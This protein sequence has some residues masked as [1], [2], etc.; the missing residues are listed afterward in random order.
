M[1]DFLKVKDF[2]VNQTAYLVNMHAG[3]NQDPEIK[4]CK[5]LSVGRKYVKVDSILC[6]EFKI[7]EN[8]RV[9]SGLVEKEYSGEDRQLFLTE[10]DAVDYI[11]RDVLL[12]RLLHEFLTSS[13]F[14]LL[15]LEKICQILGI[16]DV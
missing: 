2:K 4:P 12:K 7:S 3:R 1:P 11:R 9:W 5:V 6:S 10:S 15:Q 14:S 16:K 8:A 13:D